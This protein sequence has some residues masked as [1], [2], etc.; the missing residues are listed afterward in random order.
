MRE[1]SRREHVSRE[2]TQHLPPR[3]RQQT[4]VEREWRRQRLAVA[5]GV[6]ALLIVV[7]VPAYG[8]YDNFIAPPRAVVSTVNG[9]EFTLGQVYKLLRMIQAVQETGGQPIDMGVEPFQMLNALEDNELIRQEAP[10]LGL[11][12]SED[13]LD[14]EIERRILGVPDE[15]REALDRER[16][17]QE[18]DEQYTQYLGLIKLSKGEY[19]DVVGADLLRGKL[20]DFLS[21][22]IP[23]VQEQVRL[24]RI[25]LE[26]EEAAQE[27]LELLAG[28]GGEPGPAGETPSFQE[29]VREQGLLD[30]PLALDEEGDLGWMPRGILGDAVDGAVFDLETGQTSEPINS[31][32]GVEIYLVV[33]KA[34]ERQLDDTALERF[35]AIGYQSWLN[36]QRNAGDIQRCFGS[37]G[38][39]SCQWQYDW[40]VRQVRKSSQLNR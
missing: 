13:E 27:V 25:L 32:F 38:S 18:F 33:E 39:G 40:L 20:L 14:R 7:A 11:Q 36:G 3:Q 19:R 34:E 15:Q 22:D 6:V 30:D 4:R 23:Q 37:G 29:L 24:Y 5:I 12:V 26:T 10:S 17:K 1:R 31:F 9:T 21:A 2:G 35:R 8:Y 28:S 16:L